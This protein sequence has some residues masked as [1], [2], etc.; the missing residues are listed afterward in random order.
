MLIFKVKVK[1]LFSGQHSAI[2][3]DIK[4][5][6]TEIKLIDSDFV[7]LTIV[8]LCIELMFF[9]NSIG[10]SAIGFVSFKYYKVRSGGSHAGTNYNRF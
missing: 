6:K 10:L 4:S 2:F 7:C 1:V 3:K 8:K 5:L 9:M